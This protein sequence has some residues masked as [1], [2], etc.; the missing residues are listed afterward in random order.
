MR[1]LGEE[2]KT[3]AKLMINSL[4]GRL[5]MDENPFYSFFIKQKD[6]DKYSNKYNIISRSPINDLDFIKIELTP[7]AMKD[8][9]IKLKKNKGNVAIA[10]AITSK[11]RIKLLNAQS[12]VIENG[13][14]VLYSDTDSIFAAYKKDVSNERH[15]EIF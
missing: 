2:Y 3:F 4:Y 5:G 15:G 10:A 11:A 8:L 13:G 1:K 14:R 9:N 6:F 7:Q 12:A